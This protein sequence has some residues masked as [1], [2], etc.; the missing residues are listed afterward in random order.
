MCENSFH[1]C[2]QLYKLG[3]ALQRL[4]LLHAGEFRERKEKKVGCLPSTTL[5]R[6]GV[7]HD[8]TAPIFKLGRCVEVNGQ[9]HAPAVAAKRD[10]VPV[11]T[12]Q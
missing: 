9:A 10:T 12:G 8:A 7:S 11:S 6:F 4:Q 3:T 5:L 2:Q 1:N